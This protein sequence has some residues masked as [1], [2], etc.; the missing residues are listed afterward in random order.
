MNRWLL[1]RCIYKGKGRLAWQLEVCERFCD[2]DFLE[3]SKAFLP[4]D[5]FTCSGDGNVREPSYILLKIE[6]NW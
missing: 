1:W 2:D 4:G 6:F 3:L 5:Y